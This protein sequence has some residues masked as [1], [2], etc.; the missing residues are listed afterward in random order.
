MEQASDEHQDP[1]HTWNQSEHKAPE[2]SIGHQLQNG[3]IYKNIKP[4]M[5]IVLGLH[6]KHKQEPH[7]VSQ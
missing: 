6:K 5:L 7:L 4:I 2:K 3:S 1:K